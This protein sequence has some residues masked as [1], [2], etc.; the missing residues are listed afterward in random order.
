VPA[1]LKGLR[2]KHAG[3]EVSAL[4]FKNSMGTDQSSGTGLETS[5]APV[6]VGDMPERVIERDGLR[7]T[8][9]GAVPVVLDPGHTHDAQ[10]R[11]GHLVRGDLSGRMV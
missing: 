3:S 1:P 7:R 8:R 2:G 4:V 11:G 10:S 6:I 9:S 5:S